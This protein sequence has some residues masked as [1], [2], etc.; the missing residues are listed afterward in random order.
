[1]PYVIAALLVLLADQISKYLTTIHIPLNTGSID[2]IPGF[3]ALRN[4]HNYGAAFGILKN[5]RWFFLIITVLLFAAAAYAFSKKLI[6]SK[7]TR[8][9]AVLV[10]T[11]ALGNALDRLVFGY[12]VDMFQFVFLKNFAIFNV[13]D[14]FIT[15]GTILFC[16]LLFLEDTEE[17]PIPA[18]GAVKQKASSA[19]SAIRNKLPAKAAETEDQKPE[20]SE[21][22]FPVIDSMALDSVADEVTAVFDTIPPKSN[23]FFDE[24]AA[25]ETPEEPTAKI[26]LEKLPA[27]PK[28][29]DPVPEEKPESAEEFEEAEKAETSAAAS[30]LFLHT[31]E[32]ENEDILLEEDE[33]FTLDDI[34]AEFSDKYLS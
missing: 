3:L 18:V 2:L 30:D 16:I 23:P 28:E 33:E 24:P 20:S 27:E 4:I 22:D 11:G 32:D 5:G 17:D 34:M 9:L 14:I 1:M 7:P 10:L 15:C 26:R 29:A 21:D 6:R 31:D 13:A 25:I 19:V 8:W 12:V